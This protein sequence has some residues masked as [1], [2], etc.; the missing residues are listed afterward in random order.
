MESP[1][2]VT[3]YRHPKNLIK[4]PGT[5]NLIS[6]NSEEWIEDTNNVQNAFDSLN[7]RF[8]SAA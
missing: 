2:M 3:D 4:R 5:A 6:R 8:T 1:Y 7:N